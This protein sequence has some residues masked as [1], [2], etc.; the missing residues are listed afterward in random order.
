MDLLDGHARLVRW[1]QALA[2]LAPS[3]ERHR[4]IVVVLHQM[5]GLAVPEQRLCRRGLHQL[6][7]PAVQLLDH[8]QRQEVAEWDRFFRLLVPLAALFHHH[9]KYAP[10]AR[11]QMKQKLTL[12]KETV[13]GVLVFHHQAA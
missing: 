11:G 9:W 7:K 10:L 8:G 13:D 12:L 4:P 3:Q 2:L 5:V 1:L 6:L